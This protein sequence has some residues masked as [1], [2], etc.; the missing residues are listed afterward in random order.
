MAISLQEQLLKSG[1]VSKGKAKAAKTNKRKQTKQERKHNQET[2][3]EAKLLAEKSKAE[4]LEKDRVLNQQK[5]QLAEEKAILAQI[6]Q[7]VDD[8]KVPQD[9]EGEAY[10][11]TD[12]N[13][14]KKIYISDK[15]R[16]LIS[17]GSLA[18]VKISQSYA[19]VPA[20]VAEKIVQRDEACVLVLNINANKDVI[21]EEDPYADFQIPDDLMW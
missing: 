2:V 10:N 5:Q 6:K 18:I 15:V 11:F 20:K 13:K 14:V 17:K 16:E 21:V 4:Q 3:N 19:L 7:L 9:K 12:D 1:L 8:N